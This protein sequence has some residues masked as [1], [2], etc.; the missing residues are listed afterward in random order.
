MARLSRYLL[1]GAL[2]LGGVFLISNSYAAD[3]AGG[4]NPTKELAGSGSGGRQERSAGT[5]QSGYGDILE[6]M[7]EE[8]Q[9]EYLTSLKRINTDLR[10]E[11][12][13]LAKNYTAYRVNYERTKHDIENR[14][15]SPNYVLKNMQ[16]LEDEKGRIEGDIKKQEK[17]KEAL[18]KEVL[19]FYGGKLP[20]EL[21][22]GWNKEEKEYTD[23][24]NAIYR[25]LGWWM[26]IEYSPQWRG[27]ASQFWD[28][29]RQYYQQN[30]KE[31]DILK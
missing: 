17:G 10:N 2:F 1:L 25:Q 21:T 8:K 23:Y 19:A 20:Q 14:L 29:I 13:A 3:A 9:K 15:I 12:A 31:L 5:Q 4:E 6:R 16:N 28:Y 24:L 11:Y 22:N 7:S 18:M 26:Q 30:P 27:D